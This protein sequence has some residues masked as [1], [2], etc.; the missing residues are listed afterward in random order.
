MGGP[1]GF[2]ALMLPVAA[3]AWLAACRLLPL[4]TRLQRGLGAAVLAWTWVTVGSQLLGSQGFL[5]FG[6][7]LAWSLAALA[8]G[9]AAARRGGPG[10]VEPTE[11]PPDLLALIALALVVAPCLL[12]GVAS[13][14][15]PLKVVSDG[16]IYHLYFAIRWWKAARLEL[17]PV[18]FGESAATYFPA[19]G[20]LWFAWLTV[21]WGGDRLARVGQAPFLLLSGLTSVALARGLGAGRSAALVAACWF[22]GS[23][24][25]LLFAFEPNVD[26]IFVAGY[27]LAAY[28]GI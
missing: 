19:N 23:T 27:L 3:G 1:A 15:G 6:P 28:W 20:D 21:G 13:L 12:L 16:P 17:V 5:S 9:L 10:P 24:P 18:P 8:G 22:L 4:G 7:L 26:M 25:L 14:A 11:R 2:L